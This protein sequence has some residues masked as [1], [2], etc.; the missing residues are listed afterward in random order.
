MPVAGHGREYTDPDDV[1]RTL[2]VI[3]FV[4]LALV[5]VFMHDVTQLMGTHFSTSPSSV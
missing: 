4:S 2:A 1:S 3:G 5:M